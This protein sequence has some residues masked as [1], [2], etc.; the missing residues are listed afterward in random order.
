MN[1]QK[2]IKT[3]ATGFCTCAAASAF[4]TT[5]LAAEEKPA[6]EDWRIPFVQARY[7]KLLEIL[8]VQLGEESLT[9]TLRQLGRYCASRTPVV[10]KHKGHIDEF[11]REFKEKAGET[12]S[13][14]REKGL[15]TIVG[16]E[17][18]D[19]FCPL[20]NGTSPKVVCNCSLG[21]QQYVY[22]S[23]LGQP[24]EVTLLESVL[25]GGSRCTFE[26]RLK[27]NQVN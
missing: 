24:V 21:W 27:P 16:P 11:I 25:R 26:I 12:I 10:E 8:S 2:F 18:K 14:D 7:A 1:R 6:K 17:R 13:F 23:L 19:C 3:C 5:R 15:I 20:V 9:E 22:E 4:G